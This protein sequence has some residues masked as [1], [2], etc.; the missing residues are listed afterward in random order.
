MA[1]SLLTLVSLVCL[2]L[3]VLAWQRRPQLAIGMAVGAVLVLTGGPIVRALSGMDHMP[4]WGPALPFA[5]IAIS[6]FGFGL[7]AWFWSED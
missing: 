4:I 3:W 5:L 7:L 6:L 2:L 1:A